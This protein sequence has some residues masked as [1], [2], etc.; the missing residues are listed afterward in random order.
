MFLFT[1]RCD[2]TQSLSTVSKYITKFV[3]L[4][5]KENNNSYI[6]EIINKWNIAGNTQVEYFCRKLIS[7][8]AK[9]F[10]FV[11]WG[12]NNGNDT[13]RG[14]ESN[15]ILYNI[16]YPLQY[17]NYSHFFRYININKYFFVNHTSK[18]NFV[19]CVM[20]WKC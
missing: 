17:E 15:H 1:R 8:F 10:A 2:S 7:V 12:D 11:K 9:Q 5:S 3:I 13:A 6:A 19:P 16:Y 4:L 20:L 18:E 14:D